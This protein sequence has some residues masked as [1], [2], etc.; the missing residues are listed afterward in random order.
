LAASQ[1]V[2]QH[3]PDLVVGFGPFEAPV[4]GRIARRVGVPNVT[5]LFGCC[6]RLDDWKRFYSNYP[7]I[8][9]YKTPSDL[10]IVTNDGSPGDK[11]AE[12]LG[13]PKDRFL[14]IRNG[15]DF[16]RFQPGPRSANVREHQRIDSEQPL[17]ITVTRL[18]RE[19]KLERALQ[20]MPRLLEKFPNA[21]LALLGDGPER[22]AL[23]TRSV[24]MGLAERVRF[25]GSVEHA[26]LPEWYRSADILL[27]LLDR[28]NASNPVFEAMSCGRVPVVLDAGSVREVIRNGETGVVI[29]P[30]EL[31][32][33]GEILSDLL[34][35]QARLQRIGKAAA[36]SI[37]ELLMSIEDRLNYEV[38]VLEA[39]ATGKPIPRIT[40]A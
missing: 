40:K 15:L 27:S 35:D 20:A 18:V 3:A 14:Y 22:E 6:L 5:R 38:D 11:V 28:T 10:F 13:I 33:L 24:K 25:P 37:R 26:R 2:Q 19:K 4:A 36:T 8:A 17:L 16:D 29:S 30:G 32:R 23:Q 1:V 7:E 12:R 39:L 9:A 21:I 31:P 34:A